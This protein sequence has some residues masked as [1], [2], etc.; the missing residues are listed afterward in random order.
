MYLSINPRLPVQVTSSVHN[1]DAFIVHAGLQM[2]RWRWP[3]DSK[4]A[5][6][7]K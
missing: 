6:T 5:T 7:A 1:A 2:R 3:L 4:S